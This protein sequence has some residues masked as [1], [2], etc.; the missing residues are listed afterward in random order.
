MEASPFERSH[1]LSRSNL[2]VIHSTDRRSSV[3]KL[4]CS[5]VPEHR[6]QD[7]LSPSHRLVSSKSFTRRARHQLSIE[8]QFP[9]PSENEKTSRCGDGRK[10]SQINFLGLH[11]SAQNGDE[12][13]STRTPNLRTRSLNQSPTSRK[14][15]QDQDVQ[16]LRYCRFS[17]PNS[18]PFS[19]LPSLHQPAK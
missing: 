9:S 2:K 7:T 1:Q 5:R 11:A 14:G 13:R 10:I 8:E 18:T 6:T 12:S 4:A 15:C 19:P 16:P 3:Y 17:Q